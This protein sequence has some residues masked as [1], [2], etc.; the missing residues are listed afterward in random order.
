MNT[1]RGEVADSLMILANN[2]AETGDTFPDLLPPLLRQ[3]ARDGHPAVRVMVLHRLAFLQF[4]SPLGWELFES[5]VECDDERI[6]PSAER[7]LYY[8][9]HTAFDRVKPHLDKI[10]GSK[11]PA[12]RETWGRISA[13]ASLSGHVNQADFI[14]RLS[15]MQ[16]TDAWTGAVIV[17]AANAHLAE[18]GEA[19][20]AGLA[21]ALDNPAAWPAVLREVHALFR[22]VDPI[23][24]VPASLLRSALDGRLSRDEQGFNP[25][26]VDTW[27]CALAETRPDLALDAAE[28]FAAAAKAGRVAVY[29]DAPIARLL[30]LLFR[31]AEEREESDQGEMLRRVIAV[32][33]AFL[34]GLLEGLAQWLRDAER[35]DS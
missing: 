23:T 5:A 31:E 3:F 12:T 21:A 25:H 29:D 19:C 27:L 20:F 10:S 30:T 32:Q 4:K 11:V 35:P 15:S 33:D 2:R 18:H 17:W 6:W 24:P 9:Y 34:A 16:D 1:S 14:L 28:L 22:N 7:C 26:G 8:S 13:L